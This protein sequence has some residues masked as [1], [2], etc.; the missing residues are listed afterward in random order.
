[1]LLLSSILYLRL[2]MELEVT[3]LVGLSMLLLTA[4][5]STDCLSDNVGMSGFEMRCRVPLTLSNF[6]RLF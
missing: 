4:V 5:T 6:L 1:M 3:R 2:A